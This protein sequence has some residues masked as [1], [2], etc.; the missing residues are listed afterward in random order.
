MPE[1][2]ECHYCKC[3]VPFSDRLFID[4][5]WQDAD[6]EWDLTCVECCE[7]CFDEYT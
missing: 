5:E 6:G 1:F 4:V 2:I 7:S 3:R